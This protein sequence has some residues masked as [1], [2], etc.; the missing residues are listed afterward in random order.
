MEDTMRNLEAHCQRTH[1]R[2]LRWAIIDDE[3]DS[4]T[5][6]DRTSATPDVVHDIAT[7]GECVY[8]GYSATPQA[9]LFA[10]EGNPLFPQHF[11]FFLKSYKN[12]SLLQDKAVKE[13]ANIVLSNKPKEVIIFFGHFRCF[14]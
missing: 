13:I 11:A 12:K 14:C 7:I 8:I 2:S 5:V 6:G 4:L 3:C 9:N 10:I 1:G